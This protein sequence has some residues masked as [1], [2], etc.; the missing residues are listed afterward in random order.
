[1]A[2]ER[3]A[4]EQHHGGIERARRVEH[5]REGRGPVAAMGARRIFM[6]DMNI[7][8]MDDMN[9]AGQVSISGR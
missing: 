7:R 2:V 9:I 8:G 4:D 3:I 1:M 5:P 6:I